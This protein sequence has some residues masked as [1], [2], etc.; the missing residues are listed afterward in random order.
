TA[1][2]PEPWMIGKTRI[3]GLMARK[4]SAVAR[5]VLI[6]IVA[7]Q[8]KASA[9]PLAEGRRAR[10]P[11]PLGKISHLS[12]GWASVSTR[13]LNFAL[14]CPPVYWIGARAATPFPRCL[15]RFGS[16]PSDPIRSAG[17]VECGPGS[18]WDRIREKWA[19]SRR[20]VA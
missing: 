5:G 14:Q 12:V 11:A 15:V 9:G 4:S 16:I 19:A 20:D 6:G 17:P 10:R 8:G 7:P 18:I 3:R 2:S 1:K 13:Q